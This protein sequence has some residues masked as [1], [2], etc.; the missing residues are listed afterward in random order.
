MKKRKKLKRES[1]II[2]GP[3]YGSVSAFLPD[4]PSPQTTTLPT[5]SPPLSP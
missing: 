4:S 3:P 5:L 2:H 1:I